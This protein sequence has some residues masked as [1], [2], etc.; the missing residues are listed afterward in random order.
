MKKASFKCNEKNVGLHS[1][2]SKS[3]VLLISV[4]QSYH[5]AKY[6]SAVIK[7]I[8]QTNFG[9]CTIALA[10][11]LQRHNYRL[12]HSPEEAYEL[13]AEN[14][15]AWK[16]RNAEILA[17]FNIENQIITWDTWLGH[18]LYSAFKKEI[19]NIYSSNLNY[20][21]AIDK[22]YDSFALRIKRRQQEIDWNKNR[23]N[24]FCLEYL[25]EECAIIMPLWACIGYDYIIYPKPMTSAMES[26][27][28]LLV[29]E[30]SEKVRWL[31]LRF[32]N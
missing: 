9:S 4:G 15:Y 31:S 19:D 6:L 2:E 16:K 26:T 7:L 10:D 11:T 29:K 24:A 23:L 28:N 13:A 14:G 25:K 18:S 12:T 27:Y 21:S 8:N 17:T 30:K 5:E 20:K 3:A 32:K 22:T 1:V